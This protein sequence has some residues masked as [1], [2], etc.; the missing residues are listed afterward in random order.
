MG[1]AI[2]D[3]RSTPAKAA[4]R[5][6]ACGGAVLIEQHADQRGMSPSTRPMKPL[7][8]TWPRERSGWPVPKTQPQPLEPTR[9]DCNIS[10]PPFSLMSNKPANRD[11]R[12]D[13]DAVARS[14]LSR[15]H[16][17]CSTT[18]LS[19]SSPLK[20]G[21]GRVQPR[22]AAVQST[23]PPAAHRLD[24]PSLARNPGCE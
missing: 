7:R 18:M 5:R 20:N 11:A 8:R 6:Q 10:S 12:A 19:Q 24:R 15:R 16:E 3:P 21:R 2:Q 22:I 4:R 23:M 13:V 9:N 14:N 1:P 17:F